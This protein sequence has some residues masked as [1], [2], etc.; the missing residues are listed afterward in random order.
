MPIGAAG[1]IT[2]LNR[3]PPTDGD[4]ISLSLSPYISENTL[5]APHRIQQMTLMGGSEY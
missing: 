2:V 4:N 1:A 5:Q 3:T